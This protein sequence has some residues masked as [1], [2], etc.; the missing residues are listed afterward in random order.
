MSILKFM[1]FVL[2][3]ILFIWALLDIVRANKSLGWKV[4]WG[5]ICLAFPVVGTIIY[6]VAARQKDMQLPQDFQK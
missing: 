1:F 5:L 3:L 2:W 6:Y 4:I